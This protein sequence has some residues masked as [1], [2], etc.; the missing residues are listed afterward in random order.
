[1]GDND[2]QYDLFGDQVV[3]KKGRKPSSR[4]GYRKQRFLPHIKIPVE[5]IVFA[6]IGLL[7]LVIIS[8][9]FGVERGKSIAGGQIVEGPGEKRLAGV[10]PAP[11]EKVKEGPGVAGDIVRAVEDAAGAASGPD[12]KD[13]V[14]NAAARVLAVSAE[15]DTSRTGSGKEDVS[16][17]RGSVYIVQ[18]ASFKT[19]PSAMEEIDKLKRKGVD[20]RSAKKGPW[21]QVYAAGYGT[22]EEAK[23]AKQ[24]LIADY[25]DCFIRRRKK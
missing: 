24:E 2:Y 1:M 3:E 13:E 12:S 10:S 16:A 22:I 11:K 5:Y 7:V 21:Y 17:S 25:E 19:E 23:K 9:A 14:Q 18:L 4:G 8:Y 6:A 20:A 15:G